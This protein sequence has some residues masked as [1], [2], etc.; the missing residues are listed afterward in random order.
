[1]RKLGRE[2]PAAQVRE[3]LERLAFGVSDAGPRQFSVTVPSWRAT[4]DVSMKDDLVEEIGRMIGYDSIQPTAPAILATVPPANEERAFHHDVRSLVA[5]QGF[6][7]V[8]NY[9]FVSEE[10]ARAFG[11]D[12]ADHVTVTNPIASDQSLLRL[13]LLPEIWRNIVEN[14]KHTDAFRLFEIGREIHKRP[15]G[16][17]DEVPHLAAAIYRKDGDGKAG[18]FEMKRVALCLMPGT[19]VRPAEARTYEHPARALEIV[20]REKVIGR[21]FELHPGMVEGR[22]AILDLDLRLVQSLMPRETKYTPI[23]RYPS[24]AF[25]LSVVAGARELA[26]DLST[27]LASFAGPMLLEIEYV[28]E[29]SGPP[30]PEGQKSVSFRLT[31]GSAERTLTS[32]EV[33]QIRAA[34]IEGMQKQGYE[35][36]V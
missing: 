8:Y 32:E 17:P 4:K 22:A 29:Y 23:R 12:P 20:W 31:L 34:I 13:S 11:F 2:V 28:R 27:K 33:S 10:A 30:L 26:G 19:E 24:S 36:R 6:T 18:L 1:M 16:L 35:L 5:D 25:D 7:E 15:E 3:I 14:A 9:S 21:L